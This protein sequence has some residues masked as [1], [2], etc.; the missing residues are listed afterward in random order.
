[1]NVKTVS[2]HSFFGV[3]DT[4]RNNRKSCALDTSQNVCHRTEVWSIVLSVIAHSSDV[5]VMLYFTGSFRVVWDIQKKWI[6][7]EK[8]T[9][10]W[11]KAYFA[12]QQRWLA[13]WEISAQSDCGED[14]WPVFS[15]P[16]TALGSVKACVPY[17]VHL[18]WKNSSEEIKLNV[19]ETLTFIFLKKNHCLKKENNLTE[20]WV[21]HPLCSFQISKWLRNLQMGSQ[22]FPGIF[23]IEFLWVC[24]R[25]FGLGR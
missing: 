7:G 4:L 24:E 18:I 6:R 10:F 2:V 16:W 3:I 15:L 11:S 22:A 9:T 8:P 19:K 23:T 17:G 5:S 20:T 1:M 12:F 21:W 13:F 25:V 14:W